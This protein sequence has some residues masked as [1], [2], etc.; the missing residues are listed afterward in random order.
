[1]TPDLSVTGAIGDATEK[2]KASADYRG[3][4]CGIVA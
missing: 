3:G 2:G 1:M 4:V